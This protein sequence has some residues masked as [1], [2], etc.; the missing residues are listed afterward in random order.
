MLGVRDKKQSK[1]LKKEKAQQSQSRMRTSIYNRL[2]KS[3]EASQIRPETLKDSDS[4]SDDE[5]NQ[6]T[7]LNHSDD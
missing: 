5:A 7:P 3:R 1:K 2:F 6:S 4:S